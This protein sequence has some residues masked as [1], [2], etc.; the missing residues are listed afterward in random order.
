MILK[1][2]FH[3]IYITLAIGLL[4]S[5]ACWNFFFFSKEIYGIAYDTIVRVIT[6]L[7]VNSTV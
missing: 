7:T 3:K 1:Q 4:F 5:V 2:I 6:D